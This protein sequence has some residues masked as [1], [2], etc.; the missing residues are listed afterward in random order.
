M[1]PH[2]LN[3]VLDDVKAYLCDGFY[4]SY[5]YDLTCSRQRRIAWMQKR[6][7]DPLETI[8]SDS[9]YFWNLN[10]LRDFIAQKIDCKWFT[11]LIQGYFGQETGQMQ[12]CNVSITLIARRVHHRTG[13]R[14][15][16]RGIDDKGFVGNQCEKE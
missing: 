1:D 12:N 15:N 3:N 14:Y 9:R 6:S 10:L 8:A 2:Q 7:K 4:F 16:A 11:P 13:T 5:G